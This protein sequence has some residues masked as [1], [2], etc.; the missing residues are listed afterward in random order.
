MSSSKLAKFFAFTR[1]SVG[2]CIIF[3]GILLFAFNIGLLPSEYKEVVFSW[4]MLILVIGVFKI[5]QGGHIFIGLI[6]SAIGLHWLTPKLGFV[7]PKLSSITLPLF[8][9][10]LGFAVILH[11][12]KNVKWCSERSGFVVDKCGLTEDGK[13]KENRVFGGSKRTISD[14]TFC[15]GEVNIV[16]AGSEIDL[17]QA[18]LEE[19]STYLEINCVFGGIDI[20]VPENWMVKIDV[21]VVLGEFSEQGVVPIERKDREKVLMI[22]GHCV[23]GGGEVRYGRAR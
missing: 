14:A 1:S 21:N 10:L 20:I 5:L 2:V 15:G 6:L 4:R 12:R 23:F 13:L 22:T 11:R 18:E 16:F 17:R 3:A 19:G 9:V 8:L 7:L